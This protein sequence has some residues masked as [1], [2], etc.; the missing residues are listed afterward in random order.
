MFFLSELFIS[1]CKGTVKKIIEK[2]SGA[3]LK[4]TLRYLYV[5]SFKLSDVMYNIVTCILS[6]YMN[7]ALDNLKSCA[8]LIF[9]QKWKFQLK[10]KI[11]NAAH[12]YKLNK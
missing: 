3:E 10:L 5:K 11:C 2:T 8:Y 6:A 4:K 12:I 1:N 7:I 9:A